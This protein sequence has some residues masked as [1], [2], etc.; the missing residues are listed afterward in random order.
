MQI[1][2]PLRQSAHK[3]VGGA[4][5]TILKKFPKFGRETFGGVKII[6]HSNPI[7]R[8]RL[9]KTWLLSN[10]IRTPITDQ[11]ITAVPLQSYFK[12]V[13][14]SNPR[15]FLSLSQVPCRCIIMRSPI[16]G[17]IP[18][19]LPNKDIIL[20]ISEGKPGKLTSRNR[21]PRYLSKVQSRFG[22]RSIETFGSY[23]VSNLIP[24]AMTS[25]FY[26]CYYISW[27]GALHKSIDM[28]RHENSHTYP[29]PCS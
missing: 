25:V 16:L 2:Y 8:I 11:R 10:L 27:R 22:S 15:C 29:L 9:L 1:I 7:L 17:F 6:H 24:E 28:E 4:Y 26:K 12:T 21:L 20:D 3:S 23:S 14:V 18:V 19:Y 5:E 13:R